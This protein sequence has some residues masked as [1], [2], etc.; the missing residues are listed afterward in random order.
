MKAYA[1]ITLQIY[2][3]FWFRKFF[4]PFFQVR[5]KNGQEIFLP[6]PST[7]LSLRTSSG[8]LRHGPPR[9]Y[10][11]L[12]LGISDALASSSCPPVHLVRYGRYLI[13]R[14]P[15]IIYYMPLFIIFSHFS[16]FSRCW[17]SVWSVLSAKARISASDPFFDS[18][19]KA[20]ITFL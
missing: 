4:A 11:S 12:C 10:P 18:S 15:V 1:T 13:N 6:A 9:S 19:S 16:A 20:L 14:L 5:K 8:L 7:K 2:E 3:T 17:C